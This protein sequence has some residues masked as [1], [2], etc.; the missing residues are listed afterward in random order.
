MYSCAD[1]GSLF[2]SASLLAF[3]N[4]ILQLLV[5][6]FSLAKDSLHRC[7]MSHLCLG[8]SINQC[9]LDC[10]VLVMTVLYTNLVKFL[11][12][13]ETFLYSCV[14]I[15]LC[16]VCRFAFLYSTGSVAGSFVA[17]IKSAVDLLT[18]F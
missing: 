13:A 16:F 4:G 17:F 6:S 8:L 2:T 7:L 3:Q 9:H 15:I 10:L 1:F 14:K 12:C 11:P 18:D 5:I